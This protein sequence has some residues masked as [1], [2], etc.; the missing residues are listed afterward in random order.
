[1]SALNTEHYRVLAFLK[2]GALVRSG[3]AWRFGTARIGS[4]TVD[5]LIAVGKASHLFPGEPGECVI[6]RPR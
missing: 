6:A 2:Y 4:G 5:R 1:M 3:A